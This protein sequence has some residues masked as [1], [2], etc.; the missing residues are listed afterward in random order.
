MFRESRH[1]LDQQLRKSMDGSELMHS[2]ESLTPHSEPEQ[3]LPHAMTMSVKS[4]STSGLP[5]SPDRR[6]ANR[7]ISKEI[8]WNREFYKNADVRPPFTYASLIRRSII[9]SPDRQLTLNEIY[10]WFTRT[11]CCFRRNSA[12]WK[13]AVRHNLSLHKYF[14]RVVNEK[15]AVWTVDETEICKRRPQRLQERLPSSDS[16][17]LSSFILKSDDL[18]RMVEDSAVSV[19]IL[20]PITRIDPT[21]SPTTGQYTSPGRRSQRRGTSRVRP[22]LSSSP[23]IV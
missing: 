18:F 16:S 17:N 2:E 9:E 10:N 19:S 11:F 7:N 6:H 5:D 22:S 8:Q 20:T 3:M 12:T 4:L 15:G 13:K 1:S 23:A 21:L 14:V